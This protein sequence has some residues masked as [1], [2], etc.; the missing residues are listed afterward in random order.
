MSAASAEAGFVVERLEEPMPLPEC[1]ERFPEAWE[2]LTTRPAVLFARL[3]P[4]WIPARVQFRHGF[5]RR[6]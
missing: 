5:R 3:R 2:A 6:S 1:E 4:K